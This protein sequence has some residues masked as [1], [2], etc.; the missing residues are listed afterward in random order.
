MELETVRRIHQFLYAAEAH[1]RVPAATTLPSLAG[2]VW[3]RA[4]DSLQLEPRT[5]AM[6]AAST[7]AG[8]A[9]GVL[10][11]PLVAAR[12]KQVL[13]QGKLGLGAALCRLQPRDCVSGLGASLAT[14]V[15][16][17]VLC[18]TASDVLGRTTPF[19]EMESPTQRAALAGVVVGL[20]E[21]MLFAP[22]RRIATL[23]QG[24][25]GSVGAVIGAT[26]AGAGVSGL[27]AGALT[28]SA[29]G[30]VAGLGF[31]TTIGAVREVA[32]QSP[33]AA[34]AV[35]GALVTV[36]LANP[37][38]VVLTQGHSLGNPMAQAASDLLRS[39][40]LRG[41]TQ[42]LGL[43]MLRGAPGAAISFGLTHH[44]SAKLG[45]LFE[46]G[47]EQSAMPADHAAPR[48]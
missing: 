43:G 33:P 27:W 44:L 47:Q 35:A 18:L 48:R 30:A 5:A 19:A 6:A 32:P 37:L 3:A 26:I 21:G 16:R 4:V 7:V 36:A 40:G 17:R 1:A 10:T 31:F 24:G 25:A 22:S 45:Q 11:Y 38:D 29:R 15:P 13:A 41:L 46:D 12:T 28:A 23:Q 8:M 2:F 9:E 42:G 34:Q 39:Q 14:A 20:G